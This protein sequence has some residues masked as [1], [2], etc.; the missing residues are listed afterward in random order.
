[1]CQ[2]SQRNVVPKESYRLRQ[3][4]LLHKVAV[5]ADC[6]QNR[7]SEV[8]TDAGSCSEWGWH[9]KP[10]DWSC[11]RAEFLQSKK[12]GRSALFEA[13]GKAGSWGEF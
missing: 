8:P 9:C 1:M 3:S 12:S 10:L 5:E 4:V 11:H 6:W 7:T 2:R 13:N